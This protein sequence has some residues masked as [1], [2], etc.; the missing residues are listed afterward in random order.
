MAKAKQRLSD[1]ITALRTTGH[2]IT[3]QRQAILEVLAESLGHPDV[4]TVH[5]KVSTRFPAMSLATVYKTVAL[6]KELNQVLELGFSAWGSRYDGN[7]PYPHPHVICTQC[8]AIA[9]PEFADTAR[10]AQD[11]AARSGFRITHHRLDFFGL[12]P[13]CQEEG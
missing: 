1:M 13:R 3:P 10:M 4:E 7:R 11:M 5:Q 8:G 12:C 6:L 9:D 2:R